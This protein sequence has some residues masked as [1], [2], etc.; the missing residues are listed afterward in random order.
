MTIRERW[1]SL[2]RRTAAPSPDPSPDSLFAELDSAYSSPERSYH[3]WHHVLDCLRWLDEYADASAVRRETV[4]LL[5]YALFYHDAVY[6]P[7]ASDNEA[8]SAA[9]ATD[10]L[11]ELGVGAA[12]VQTVAALILATRH[13]ASPEADDTLAA[14]MVDIDL[15]I[16]GADPATYTEYTQAIAR[17][18]A[19]MDPERF[20]AGRRAILE[21]FLARPT[22]YTT[23]WFRA[24]LEERARRNLRAELGFFSR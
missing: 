3:T 12:S 8:A 2:V 7:G 4:S 1:R 5:E 20:A 16:L 6:R 9:L 17:E 15:S 22:I 18:Y 19:H 21:A 24:R 23:H 10:R 13:E 11:A 14:A